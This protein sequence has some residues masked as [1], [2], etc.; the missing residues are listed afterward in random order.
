MLELLHSCMDKLM[1][2]LI[3]EDNVME[4]HY[5]AYIIQKA[6]RKHLIRKYFAMRRRVVLDEAV[7]HMF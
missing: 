7:W 4:R 3:P 5:A 6:Y 1:D 2:H